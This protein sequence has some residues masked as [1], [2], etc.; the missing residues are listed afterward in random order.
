MGALCHLASANGSVNTN[1]SATANIS[2]GV[3]SS[4]ATKLAECL[5]WYDAICLIT[6]GQSISTDLVL[7]N[8]I[9]KKSKDKYGTA[10]TNLKTNYNCGTACDARNKVLIEEMKPLVYDFWPKTS[11]WSDIKSSFKNIADKA[12][13][14]FKNTFSRRLVGTD[15]YQV[16]LTVNND[17]TNLVTLGENS[18]VELQEASEVIFKV[19]LLGLINL[20]V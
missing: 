17:G 9:F 12:S 1:A 19:V 3:A 4:L 20:F 13:D 10:C 6:T 11:I 8:D 15:S 14:W 7:D 5:P 16:L 2:L 18:G